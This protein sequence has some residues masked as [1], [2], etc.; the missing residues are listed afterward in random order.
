MRPVLIAVAIVVALVI[1][2]FTI[3]SIQVVTTRDRAIEN[4]C[5]A[6]GGVLVGVGKGNTHDAC[7]RGPIEIVPIEVRP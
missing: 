3:K 5:F 1:I 6:A 2:G 7:V 4:A